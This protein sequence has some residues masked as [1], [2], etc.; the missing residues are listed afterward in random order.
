MEINPIPNLIRTLE[1]DRRE[2][3]KRDS[4][5]RQDRRPKDNAKAAAVY[6]P[7]GKLMPEEGPR[8]DIIA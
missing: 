4:R 6:T 8:I 2:N 7:D 5:K 3:D 1:L